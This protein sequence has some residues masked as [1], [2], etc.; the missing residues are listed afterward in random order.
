[1][2]KQLSLDAYRRLPSAERGIDSWS[3]LSQADRDKYR[4]EQQQASASRQEEVLHETGANSPQ[5][6]E[7]LLPVIAPTA[8]K[9]TPTP[10]IVSAAIERIKF[11]SGN[12]TAAERFAAA[13]PQVQEI[14]KNVQRVTG[15]KVTQFSTAELCPESAEV[16]RIRAHAGLL[17][18]D[19]RAKA[20][21]ESAAVTRMRANA[22]LLTKAEQFAALPARVQEIARNFQ[23]AS[24][25]KIVPEEAKDQ[26]CTAP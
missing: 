25:Q 3:R 10:E 12:T 6:A 15:Q 2:S 21:P 22:G 11:N 7:T 16:T 19:E 9:V 1:M 14:M 23:A 4:A 8:A 24:G 18:A 20:F 17:T 26:S 13:D 5:Q